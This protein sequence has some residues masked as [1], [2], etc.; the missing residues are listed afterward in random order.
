MMV[1]QYEVH[2]ARE[3]GSEGELLAFA[4]QKRMAF[5]EQVTLYTDDTKQQ[6]VLGFKARQ[7]LD[8]AATY[9]ITDASGNAIGLF[10]KD[11]G[12]SLLRST[13]HVEQP[14]LGTATGQERSQLVAI[15]R[16]FAESMSW[17]PYHFD[18]TLDG[19]PA[20]SVVKQ[21]GLR[22][23][24]VVDI[25]HPQVDRRIV[26]AMAVGLDALQGR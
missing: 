20:F 6:P 12:R 9:D 2:A 17:L 8:L 14:G 7:R 26:I 11:F 3:D 21:W 16:R 24:Y 19:Q 25:P 23:R 4:Q 15:L 22:D 1:N 10:R 5:R 18:F 13:W